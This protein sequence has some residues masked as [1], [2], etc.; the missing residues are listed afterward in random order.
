MF[1][2]VMNAPPGAASKS[3]KGSY[4]LRAPNTTQWGERHAA[5][6]HFRVIC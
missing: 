5:L 3:A 6:H 4:F 1:C 2:P